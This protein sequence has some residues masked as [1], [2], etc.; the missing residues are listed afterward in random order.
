MPS[1][2]AVI[3]YHG[4]RGTV[5]RAKFRD[6]EGAQ[7]MRTLGRAADG[8]TRQRAEREIGKL[9]DKVVRERWRKPTRERLSALVDEFLDEYL[10]SRGRRRSTVLDYTNT[11]RKHVL[12]RSAMSSSRSLRRGRSCSTATSSPSDDRSWRRRRSR[13]TCGRSPRCSSTPGG[14]G[15]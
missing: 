7:V 9:L 15:E 5:Y 8:W 2:A 4:K 3:E 10:P 13:T 14:A 11:L 1:G 6:T 12:P